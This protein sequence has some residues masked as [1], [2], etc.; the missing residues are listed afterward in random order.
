MEKIEVAN[1]QLNNTIRL[2]DSH[3]NVSG[4]VGQEIPSPRL[5]LTVLYKDSGGRMIT[6]DT[7]PGFRAKPIYFVT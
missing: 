1:N 6:A 3:C 4:N 7:A 2:G 5:L